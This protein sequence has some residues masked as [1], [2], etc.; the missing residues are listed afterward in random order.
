MSASFKPVRHRYEDALARLPWRDV[1]ERV[2]AYFTGLGYVVET[3]D[4]QV[5]GIDLVLRHGDETTLVL[6]KHWP[7]FQIPADDVHRL[8]GQMAPAG[9]TGAILVT[10]GEFSRT[11]VEAASRFR[12][13]RLI[14]GRALR[15]LLG[16]LEI[17]STLHRAHPASAGWAPVHGSAPARPSP[18]SRA[19]A[20]AAVAAVLVMAAAMLTLYTWYIREIH[21]AQA[22]A[23]RAQAVYQQAGGPPAPPPFAAERT[24]PGKASEP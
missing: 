10:S 2:A 4:N 7:A 3:A 8:I 20:T 12:H 9:A 5:Q 11:A 17:A 15:A 16:P 6:C 13:V 14:D 19:A 22:G 1:V 18:A 21:V 23:G 24:L